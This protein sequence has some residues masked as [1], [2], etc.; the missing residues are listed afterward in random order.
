MFQAYFEGRRLRV[1]LRES[2]DQMFARASGHLST[3]SPR[4][5]GTS[6]S[7]NRAP[8]TL[9]A[10]MTRAL[11]LGIPASTTVQIFDPQSSDHV[12]STPQTPASN[13][14]AGFQYYGSPYPQYSPYSGTNAS[15]V[16]ATHGAVP[17][18]NP[19]NTVQSSSPYAYSPF[20]ST[21]YTSAYQVPA[22][23]YAS[24]AG[25]SAHTQTT[26]SPGTIQAE[27]HQ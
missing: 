9:E 4:N 12:N 2:H 1:E 19:M 3:G 21:Q 26:T 22:Y 7:S 6:G 10:A 15:S 25:E 20:A 18:Y 16:D 8:N 23:V 27:S 14:Y 11:A 24:A 5:R 17:V 13:L